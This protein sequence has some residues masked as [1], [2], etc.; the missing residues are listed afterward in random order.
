MSRFTPAAER[1]KKARLLI[2]RARD[3]AVPAEAGKSDLSYIAQV[4]ALLQEARDLVK[5]IPLSPSTTP[6]MKE[7]V[8]RIF[9]EAE[10]ANREILR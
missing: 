2:Q 10:Q 7:D 4:K 8:S 6:E 9:Q 3:L 1:I 5:F